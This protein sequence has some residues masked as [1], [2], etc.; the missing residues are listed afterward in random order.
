MTAESDDSGGVVATDSGDSGGVADSHHP[1]GPEDAG[2][3]GIGSRAP[4][5]IRRTRSLHLAWQCGVFVV[6]LAVVIGGII[7]LPLPGPGWL[8][9]FG[10]VAIWGT[11][12]H[13]AQRA[14]S[15]TKH[16]AGAAAKAA[17]RRFKDGAA[18]RG[19]E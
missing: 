13:W 14:L 15:W 9:I 8:V 7:L 1:G 16:K 11:E 5:F 2:G 4:A 17:R 19:K 6:G 3:S 10:G 18:T 12:F